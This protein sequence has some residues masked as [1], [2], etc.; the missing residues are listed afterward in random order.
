MI[1]DLT[2]FNRTGAE[3]PKPI[4]RLKLYYL[5]LHLNSTHSIGYHRITLTAMKHMNMKYIKKSSH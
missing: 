4:F 1:H 5:D 2:C 3:K